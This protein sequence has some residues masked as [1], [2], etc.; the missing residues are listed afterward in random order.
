MPRVPT[1]SEVAAE[2][3]A[4]NS[5]LGTY[6]NFTNLLDLCGLALPIDLSDDAPPMG[7]TLLA[8]AWQDEALLSWG[9]WIHPLIARRAGHRTDGAT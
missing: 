1:L 3:V 2:P 7:L 8:P 9:E 4:A 6:T 5:A